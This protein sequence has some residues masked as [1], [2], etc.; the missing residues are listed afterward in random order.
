M[1]DWTDLTSIWNDQQ[2][3]GK[4]YG[5]WWFIGRFVAFRSLGRGF[6]SRSSRHIGTLG[7]PFTRLWR[8]GVKLRHSIQLQSGEPL[9]NSEL[10][11]AL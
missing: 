4:H 2:D 8:F 3:M 10:E 11:E 9:S 6:E 7:K 5:A 1:K